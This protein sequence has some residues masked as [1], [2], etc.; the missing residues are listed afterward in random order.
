M[1]NNTFDFSSYH[2][3]QTALHDWF[4]RPQHVSKEKSSYY[5]DGELPLVDWDEVFNCNWTPD[6]W[7]KEP[8]KYVYNPITDTLFKYY[9]RYGLPT[10]EEYGYGYTREDW[11]VTANDEPHQYFYLNN[12]NPFVSIWCFPCDNTLKVVCNDIHIHLNS[13][14]SFSE[15]TFMNQCITSNPSIDIIL[16]VIKLMNNKKYEGSFKPVIEK[17]I[18]VFKINRSQ[19]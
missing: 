11:L 10:L 2:K 12:R 1:M 19:I 8:Y 13:D 16:K 5:C 15:G 3:E 7:N 6:K 18:D 17:L 9:G 14:G 4:V